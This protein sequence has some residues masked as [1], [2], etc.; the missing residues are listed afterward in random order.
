[1][2]KDEG[3]GRAAK[4][5]RA[6]PHD[7][8]SV[9]VSAIGRSTQMGSRYGHVCRYRAVRARRRMDARPVSQADVRG[10]PVLETNEEAA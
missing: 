5:M 2:G 8:R 3:R 10:V 7:S 1:M 4:Q 6:R 9:G